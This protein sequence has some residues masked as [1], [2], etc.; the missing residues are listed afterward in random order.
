VL[1]YATILSTVFS[2][3]VL[4][5]DSFPISTTYMDIANFIIIV[6]FA[7]LGAIINFFFFRAVIISAMKQV[8]IDL[9]A[10][11]AAIRV[12]NIEAP[13]PL[14]HSVDPNNLRNDSP[15]NQEPAIRTATTLVT[16]SGKVF[17]RESQDPTV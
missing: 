6:G 4:R 8:F 13:T 7:I 15:I 11:N 10:A 5:F 12:V 9:Q 14:Q 1:I 2:A 3:H 16:R 17:Q